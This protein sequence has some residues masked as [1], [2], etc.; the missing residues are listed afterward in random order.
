MST[1]RFTTN[2]PGHDK[3]I[4]PY[5]GSKIAFHG[6]TPTSQRV[7]S[8]LSAGLSLFTATGASVIASSAVTLSGVYTFTTTQMID[9]WDAI[10]EM[11][12]MMVEKGL[13]KGGA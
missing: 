11:R 8:V 6:S 13:H 9:M 4:G 2:D 10:K 3:V 5:T 7:A 12:A 1:N